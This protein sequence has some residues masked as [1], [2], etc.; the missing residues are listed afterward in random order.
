MQ[1][2]ELYNVDQSDIFLV[3]E[4]T[5]PIEILVVGMNSKSEL[6]SLNEQ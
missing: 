5:P 1:E 3:V 2:I 6:I 4:S